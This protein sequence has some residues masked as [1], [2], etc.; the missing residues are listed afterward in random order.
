MAP[1]IATFGEVALRL[2]P[3]GYERLLQS[4]RFLAGFS[5]REAS[6]AISLAQFGAAARFLTVLPAANPIAE[7]FLGE[8]RRFDVDARHI[9][10]EPGRMPLQ[11]VETGVNQRPSKVLYDREHSALALARSGAI[12]WNSALAGVTW[13]HVTGLT[14]ALS[15]SAAEL[16]LEALHTARA[17]GIQTS[18]DLDFS[19]DL[20]NWGKTAFE[21]MPALV[22][23]IDLCIANEQDCRQ[24][25]NLEVDIDVESGRLEREKYSELAER[26]LATYPNLRMIALTVRDAKSTSH[27]SWSACLHSGAE[28]LVSRRYHLARIVDHAGA[29]DS[30]AAGLIYALTYR[31]LTHQALTEQNFADRF[32]P[33]DA[34]EF[35]AAAGCLK[36]SVPGDFNRFSAEEVDALL[37]TGA[38]GYNS[39]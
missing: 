15:A 9:V 20:W 4:P 24:A 3:P 35:A 2:S 17:M 36:H 10:R 32:S 39:S 26:V 5:G 28:F 21:V 14:P 12:N 30:F 7:A 31:A 34:L 25:L 29:R 37:K 16:T 23:S 8:L 1:L 18:C 6:V 38:A 33:R 19:E 11:F 13:F 22:K 27:I